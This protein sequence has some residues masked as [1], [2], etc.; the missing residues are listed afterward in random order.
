MRLNPQVTVER[1]SP[2][3]AARLG[4]ISLI[5]VHATEGS[6]E[7]GD[8]DL[9]NLGAFF[10]ESKN[11]VSSHVAT[12]GDGHSARFVPD[13][14]AAWHVAG[15]NSVA[16][17]IE[18]IGHTADTHWPQ[19]EVEETARWIARW[20]KAY[21]VPIGKASVSDGHVLS[22]GVAR[23][24]DLGTIGGGHHDPGSGYP[25]HHCLDLARDI[26]NKLG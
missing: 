19:A 12:N 2:C 24:S 9:E 3:H 13:N 18:Q 17:G 8:R 23:H 14:L 20:S 1:P 7:A 6:R 22:G 26:R 5:V 15:Y 4:R 21:G 25:L 16:L 11:Q 10:G